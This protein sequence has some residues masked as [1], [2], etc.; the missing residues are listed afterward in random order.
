MCDSS[1]GLAHIASGQGRGARVQ[2]GNTAQNC[3]DGHPSPHPGQHHL[4]PE[5][6]RTPLQA[7]RLLPNSSPTQP[8]PPKSPPY[9]AALPG[10]TRPHRSARV[11]RPPK[12]QPPTLSCPKDSRAA[13]PSR[14]CGWG[15]GS[16][17]AGLQ[18]VRAGLQHLLLYPG[19]DCP[20]AGD[21]TQPCLV[22]GPWGGGLQ[23]SEGVYKAS[24]K[25]AHVSRPKLGC[26][27]LRRGSPHHSYT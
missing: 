24:E 2:V 5:E 20:A 22:P 19:S 9:V 1:C 14:T 6:A 17:H 16:V 27:K 8:F 4:K 26:R 10:L 21:H 13:R 3:R 15:A 7:L 11:W 25:A 23:G 12:P 18:G